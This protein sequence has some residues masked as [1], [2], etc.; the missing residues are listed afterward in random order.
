VDEVTVGKVKCPLCGEH[1]E[2][3]DPVVGVVWAIMGCEQCL[4]EHDERAGELLDKANLL[5]E[6]A[7]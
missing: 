1:R 5:E 4:I 6:E 3:H 2:P 7:R